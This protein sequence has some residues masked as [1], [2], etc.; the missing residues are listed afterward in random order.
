MLA[1][2]NLTREESEVLA[3]L[4]F[5]AMLDAD[6]LQSM[7]ASTRRRS[8]RRGEIIHHEDDIA[9]DVF[10]VTRGHVKHRITAFD[11]RQL[12]HAIQGPGSFFG[13]VSVVDNSRRAGDAV[14]LTD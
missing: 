5:F 3:R 13:V 14:G 11:G 10:V 4:P 2:H 1:P 12:T 7:A 8:Y 9:G 6:A